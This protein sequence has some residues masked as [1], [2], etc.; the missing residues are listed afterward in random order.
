MTLDRFTRWQAAPIHF[1]LSVVIAAIVVGAIMLV[2]YPQPYFQAAGGGT[3]ILLLVGVDVVIGP[4]LTLIVFDTKK[5]H[6]IWDLA[7]I[8]MLQAAALTY[9]V[10]IMFSARPVFVAFADDRFE[11]VSANEVSEADLGKA[12]P[13]FQNR[14]LT[15]PKVVGVRLPADAAERE[16]M[17][18]AAL[19]G[20]SIGLFPQHFVPYATVAGSAVARSRPLSALREKHP[21]RAADIDAIVAAS[22]GPD[23][24]LRYLPLQTH[25]GPLTV[26]IDAPRGDIKAV[27]AV[28]PY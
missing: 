17:M 19:L 14:P 16:R 10:S 11:L 21:D 3:L 2:W 6:L 5:K 18:F 25:K 15:G 22:G 12:L 8:A 24:A 23:K 20:G 28:D 7:V 27:V 9:G 13:E 4:L 26:V 1:A